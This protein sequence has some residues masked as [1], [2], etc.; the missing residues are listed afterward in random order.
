M[1]F[2]SYVFI[3]LFLPL[4][5]VLFHLLRRRG[6][7]RG[8]ILLLT[9]ASLTFY[10]WWSAQYL[11]LLIPLMLIDF[12]IASRMV[13]LRR[14]K[15]TGIKLLLIL[16]VC[17]NL[18]ALGYYKYANFFVDNA[19]T[20]FNT[21][22]FLAT[23]V[24]PIG[25]SFFTFQKIAFLIDVYY[26]K[27]ER[28][29][30]LDYS[31]FVT[32]FPQ[33]IA[34]PIVHHS[35]MMPQFSKLGRIE[36]GYIALGL[37]IFSIGLAK[38]VLLADSAAAY[39]S[40]QFDAAAAGASLD[41]LAAWSGALAYTVQLY[42]DFSAYSDMAMGI[43]LLFGIRLPLNFASPYKANSIIDFWRR[44]HMTLSRFL[45]DYL[46]IPLG[47]NRKG[48]GRRFINLFLTM[49]LGGIWHGAGWTFA[50]WGALHGVYLII[51]HGWRELRRRLGLSV[52]AH[53]FWGRKLAQLI[54]FL[55]VVVAWVFF[56]AAD[57]DSAMGILSAMAGNNGIAA[58]ASLAQY[59]PELPVSH[60]PVDS[61]MGLL[62]AGALL[63]LAWLAPNTQQLTAYAGPEGACGSGE[64]E[65]VS[66]RLGWN[67]S[68]GW[69]FYAAV[70][71][72]ISFMLMSRVSEFIYFQF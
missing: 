17:I 25:I 20:L 33:L 55:A 32:F 26:G 72:T 1:L 24:L 48:R 19:N 49:L 37:T 15:R 39:A 62:V 57:V 4:T 2:N 64:A 71:L 40:P 69:A 61:G 5:V 51:N 18:G 46:Y 7:E 38:K 30:L 27:V 60:S 44:W 47:G 53:S 65:P 6:L 54:T 29:N 14:Q 21:E 58:P 56:R 22:L 59:A 68:R 11:L 70:L 67:S 42:F 50:I 8:S 3:C 9:L 31:L 28:F 36:A 45:R 41:L 34:G 52:E 12:V 35:E 43:G 10:G 23:I 16:G 66:A 13:R 63:L